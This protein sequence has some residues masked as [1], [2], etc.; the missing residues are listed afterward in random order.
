M[1]KEQYESST[2]QNNCLHW[3]VSPSAIYPQNWIFNLG[4]CIEAYGYFNAVQMLLISNHPPSISTLYA[5]S[6]S[7]NRQTQYSQLIFHS[8]SECSSCWFWVLIMPRNIK[9]FLG[10][11]LVP[12]P[13]WNWI[14]LGS[15]HILKILFCFFFLIIFQLPSCSFVQRFGEWYIIYYTYLY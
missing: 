9:I 13:S 14:I 2:K 7:S 5:Q 11:S 12:V 6:L 10:G 4:L 8:A 15:L 1:F 3:F